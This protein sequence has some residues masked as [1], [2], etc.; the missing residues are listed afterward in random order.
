MDD[1]TKFF[2][3]FNETLE[4]FP[5]ILRAL[6]GEPGLAGVF[7]EIAKPLGQIDSIRIVD[8]A[9][10]NGAASRLSELAEVSP[11]IVLNF[12]SKFQAAGFGDIIKKLGISNEWLEEFV[13]KKV[14]AP[15]DTSNGPTTDR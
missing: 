3:F 11:R 1:A 14:G 7:G 10:Q 15:G 2:L 5:E 9:G 6:V 12:L 13:E 4:Q 8:F